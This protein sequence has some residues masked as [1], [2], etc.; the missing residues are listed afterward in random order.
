MKPP[1]IKDKNKRKRQNRETK[2]E[3]QNAV[4]V[5]KP[6]AEVITPIEAVENKH[7]PIRNIRPLAF[8]G[9]PKGFFISP[10]I[11]VYIW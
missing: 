9:L 7:C 2:I 11:S 4:T 1:A 10:Y 3:Y 5:E 8:P 6:E